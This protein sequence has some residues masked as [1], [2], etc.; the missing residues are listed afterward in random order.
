MKE[1][2]ERLQEQETEGEIQFENELDN[3]AFGVVTR[4]YGSALKE[5]VER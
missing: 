2:T 3:E 5:L 1:E 4:L